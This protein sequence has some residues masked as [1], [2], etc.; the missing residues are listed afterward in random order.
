MK[1]TKGTETSKPGHH[2]IHGADPT[3]CALCMRSGADLNTPCPGYQTAA[4]YS[5]MKSKTKP[6]GKKS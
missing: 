2:Q 3:K 6:K 5:A 1:K 4:E